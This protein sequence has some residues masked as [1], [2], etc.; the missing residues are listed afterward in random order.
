MEVKTTCERTRN[1]HYFRESLVSK[2]DKVN[3]KTNLEITGLGRQ[4]FFFLYIDIGF[5]YVFG[6]V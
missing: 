5:T 1:K 2:R 6:S 4:N 3:L